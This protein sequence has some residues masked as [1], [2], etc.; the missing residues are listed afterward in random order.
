MRA[1]TVREVQNAQAKDGSISTATRLVGSRACS[2]E[3]CL[4]GVAYAAG[5]LAGC[6]VRVV[7]LVSLDLSK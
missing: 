3:P 1:G 7:L 2:A 5:Y 4:Q 6:Q